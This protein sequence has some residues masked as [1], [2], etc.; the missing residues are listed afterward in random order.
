MRRHCVRVMQLFVTL[1][2]GIAILGSLTVWRL[3][4]GPVSLD[5]LTPTIE[6][7]FAAHELPVAVQVENTTLVWGGWSRV[8]DLRANNVR[9]FGKDGK[10][11]AVLPEV[12]IGLSAT[13]LIKGDLAI[14]RLDVYGLRA[15]FERFADGRMDFATPA[16]DGDAANGG[17]SFTA[18]ASDLLASVR[19]ARGLF[20]YLRRF[21]ILSARVRYLDQMNH[22]DWRMPSA[23]MITLFG[24]E[25]IESRF[26]VAVENA[27]IRSELAATVLHDRKSARIGGR[28]DFKDLEPTLLARAVPQVSRLAQIRL[29]FAGSAHFEIAS[30]WRLLG[31]RLQLASPVG[32]ALVGVH[33]PPAG[34]ETRVTMRLEQVNLAGLARATPALASLAGVDV[35]ISGQI[36]GSASAR[37]F[38]LRQVDLT[39]GSGKVEVPG[40]LPRPVD[41]TGGRLRAQFNDDETLVT[42]NEFSLHLGGPRIRL[43]GTARQ[44]GGEYRMDMDGGVAHVPMASLE[45]LWPVT[46]A[47]M[48]R[49][50]VTAKIVDGMVDDGDVKLVATAPIDDMA[51]LTVHEFSGTLQYRGLSVD[52]LTPMPKVTDISGTASF[53][54][55]RFDLVVNEGR[56]RDLAIERA[57]INMSELDTDNEK[58]LIDLTLN[59]SARTL[60]GVLDEKPL[61]AL[62]ELGLRPEA[63]TGSAAV[64]TKFRFPLHRNLSREEIRFDAS[65]TLDGLALRPGPAAINVED[66]RIEFDLSNDGL[67]ATG[68]AD[69]SGVQATID[70]KERFD[71]GAEE[72]RR[73]V[74]SGRVADMGKPGFH[75]PALPFLSG[76]GD[77]N[78]AYTMGPGG[79]ADLLVN[80]ELR[81]TAIDLP[82]LRWTKPAG[83]GGNANIELSL[84]GKGLRLV[85]KV[86]IDAG[87]TS[88]L[89]SAESF[90]D[91]RT[92]WI[93]TVDRF[94]NR[95]NDLKGQI[96]LHPDGAVSANLTGK[97]FDVS[98]IVDLYTAPVTDNGTEM[99]SLPPTTVRARIDELLW[100]KDRR[101]RD[102]DVMVK[103]GDGAVQGLTLDGSIG[104]DGALTIRYLPGPDGQVLRVTSDDFGALL[105]MSPSRSRVKGGALVIRGL[106]R[107]ADAPIEGS[108]YASKFTLERAPLL[109]R[110]L[111]VASLTGIFDAL[112]QR[113]LAFD[114]FEGRFAYKDGELTFAKANAHGSSIGVTGGGTYDIPQDSVQVSGTVVPAYTI[115]RV[116]GQIPVLGSLITGG[117]NEG[118]FAAT[119]RVEGPIEKPEVQVNPLSA[120]AP[121]FLRNL[122]GLGADKQPALPASQ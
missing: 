95:G 102:T 60:A 84:D 111:Q 42:V 67:A 49:R 63:V 1:I 13:G 4:Q 14:S 17:T 91:E 24:P 36:D 30:N 23:D 61:G 58:I 87:Q 27:G 6:D 2:V 83:A 43:T 18:V 81:D 106:R 114:A 78:V 25:V 90:G 40:F 48:A 11:V 85:R 120:L 98:G 79:V 66:G 59:G 39:A 89:G 64:R 26:R 116:L 77:A 92:A 80:L 94:R 38:A 100:S 96:E 62:A 32:R 68:T 45:T 70:W 16:G 74:V 99:R 33:Y 15:R 37:R 103:Y 109:A 54:R 107:G 8:F 65:G 12:S 41:V 9:L 105:S 118:I 113:G 47:K 34:G 88:L 76:P 56:L 53:D 46:L 7:S 110:V 5:F 52:Y 21:S 108:F 75:L 31:L 82:A 101:V 93:A 28:V 104:D 72:R 57:A 86:S 10:I 73:L 55:A 29:P 117:E 121:G 50:W 19:E 20:R 119:Y 71:T 3:H 112:S 69:L 115:N 22:Q 51:L 97:R 35:P 44:Q 122:F